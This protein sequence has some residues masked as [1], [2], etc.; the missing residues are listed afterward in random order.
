LI[1]VYE[2]AGMV[3]GPLTLSRAYAMIAWCDYY[4]GKN[5]EAIELF[6]K[7]F[8]IE[9]R[10]FWLNYNLGV[11]Y[12]R[13]GDY[14]T[15]LTYLKDFFSLDT[16]TFEV[17]LRLDNYDLWEPTLAKQYKEVSWGKLHELMVNSYKLAILANGQLKNPFRMKELS[18]A[19]I[20]SGLANQDPFFY[21]YAGLTSQ[22]PEVGHELFDLMVHPSFYF[23]LIGQERYLVQRR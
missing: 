7:A 13:S 22:R 3:N 5:T 23:G 20:E 6:K 12:F 10:Q 16:E 18:L 8:K 15:T 14:E 19:A 2:K 17:S 9:P 4:L 1:P 21:Y 11:I